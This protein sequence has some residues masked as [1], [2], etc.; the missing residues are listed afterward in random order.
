VASKRY[1]VV[2]LLLQQGANS[3]A[4]DIAGLTLFLSS[5]GACVIRWVVPGLTPLEYFVDPAALACFR[6]VLGKFTD[7]TC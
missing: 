5:F 7:S 3:H 4:E 1:D 6:L 2:A